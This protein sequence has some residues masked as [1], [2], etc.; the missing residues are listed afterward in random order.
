MIKRFF[1]LLSVFTLLINSGCIT[2]L[3]FIAGDES[4]SAKQTPLEKSSSFEQQKIGAYRLQ[5]LD[6]IVI[7]FSGIREQQELNI[8]IDENGEINL[9]HLDPIKAAGLTTSELERKIEE[10][11][12]KGKIYKTVSVNVTMTAKTYF[13]QGEVNSPGQ[14]P[15]E[16][17][18]TLLQAIAA[19][20]GYTPYASNRITITR[21]GRIY[22]FNRKEL[23]KDP[24]KDVQIEPEDII[25][26]WQSWY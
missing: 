4:P 13:I 14:Y 2:S 21:G 19:A 24:T 5:P 16:G 1:Y 18:K 9:L 23:E 10:A 15:L 12:I 7:H 25:K 6:P 26:V 3:P 11:Y 20:R 17:G 8:V 22:E